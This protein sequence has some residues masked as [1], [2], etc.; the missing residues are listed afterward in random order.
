MSAG[1]SSTATVGNFP[2]ARKREAQAR[3]TED[4]CLLDQDQ[5]RLV[6]FDHCRSLP[7]AGWT[8][9]TVNYRSNHACTSSRRAT[10]NPRRSGSSS[11]APCTRRLKA[12]Q[13]ERLR[14]FSAHDSSAAAIRQKWWA[15]AWKRTD[16]NDEEWP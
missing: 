8:P 14:H 11:K 9:Y 13:Q 3:L 12:L 15:R 1:G 7:G 6:E 16:V 4:A 10:A 2:I 5:R